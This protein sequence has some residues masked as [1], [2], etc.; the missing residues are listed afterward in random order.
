MTVK[1][2]G[3]EMRVLVLA[4][5]KGTRMKSKKA[6]VLHSAG[7]ALLIEHVANA[8]KAVSSHVSVIV[9]HQADQVRAALTG[10]E[11]IEQQEQLGTGH[12][13]LSARPAFE[14][15]RGDVLVLP[16]DIPLIE[17]STLDRLVAF[18]RSGGFSAT[19]LTA[20]LDDPFGYGRIVRGAGQS[21]ERIVEQRDATP[22]IRAI[23]E[24][25]SGVYV[26]D[27]GALFESLAGVRN[28]NAQGEYY[29]TD[30]F[31]ILVEGQR[32]V[33]AIMASSAREILGV[34]TRQE[35]AV[36]DR[37]LRDR[38]RAALMTAGVTLVD[39]ATAFIDMNVEIGADTVIHPFVRIEGRTVIGEDAVIHSFAR[40][41]NARVGSRSTVLDGS[42]VADSEIGSDVSVGPYAHLRMG[43]TIADTA[44]V[45]NFVE[46]K[47]SVIGRNTKAMH[48]AYL[49]DATIG[50]N[51]NIGAGTITCNYDGVRKNPTTIEDDVFIGSDSQLIAPVRIGKGAYVA[52]G[53]SIT[54]DVPSD[55]LGIARGRQIN[56]PDWARERKKGK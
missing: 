11:F 40:L 53:S 38:K 9:G 29:L 10:V 22:E 28:R 41:T 47:K 33:G 26:F 14:G 56:K 17:S 49:G 3:R 4:A 20:E 27:A 2:P 44:R 8:A 24:V 46:V 15:Y 19:V 52:A 1:T 55:S 48:L 16:G 43:A 25:N 51:V 35:L 42:I 37:E 21:L 5:G 12:A 50:A 34:N 13:A 45:G 39:P 31:G 32:P 7:G 23:R 6:K 54:E 30:V 36:V 18:H